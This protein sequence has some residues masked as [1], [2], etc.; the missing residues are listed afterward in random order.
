LTDGLFCWEKHRFSS[1]KGQSYGLTDGLFCWEKH[2]FSSLK[3]RSVASTKLSIDFAERYFCW[4]KIFS[5]NYFSKF[6]FARAL[7]SKIA[8]KLRALRAESEIRPNQRI[9]F[10]PERNYIL[11]LNFVKNLTLE[12]ITNRKINNLSIGVRN[13]KQTL[14]QVTAGFFL[15]KKKAIPFGLSGS[16][17]KIGAVKK[18]IPQKFASNMQISKKSILK[19]PKG[20]IEINRACLYKYNSELQWYKFIKVKLGIKNGMMQGVE[21]FERSIE[22]EKK[23]IIITQIIQAKFVPHGGTKS[24]KPKVK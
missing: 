15:R 14:Y 5:S 2:R 24:K 1:L 6:V 12:L 23:P 11:L 16:Q 22:Q 17:K 8:A 13:A 10:Q 7:Q 9:D 3:G 4:E 20:L 19:N 21:L 18:N